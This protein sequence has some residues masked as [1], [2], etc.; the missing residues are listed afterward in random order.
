MVIDK[1]G[2]WS[3]WGVGQFNH[4]VVCQRELVTFE[5]SGSAILSTNLSQGVL[6]LA[7]R[8][9]PSEPLLT[10][11]SDICIEGNDA[12]S[13]CFEWIHSKNWGRTAVE[14][15]VYSCTKANIDAGNCDSRGG[16]TLSMLFWDQNESTGVWREFA[17]IANEKISNYKFDVSST[18]DNSVEFSLEFFDFHLAESFPPG[19]DLKVSHKVEAIDFL[20]RSVEAS[21]PMVVREML[22]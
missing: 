19:T 20:N 14:C 5:S 13:L 11:R 10:S 2:K 22:P 17:E 6:K 18:T 21:Q 9:A 16:Q 8:I 4:G 1:T 15:T 3:D 12:D 7:T